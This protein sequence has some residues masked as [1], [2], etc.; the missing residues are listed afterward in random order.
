MKKVIA[1][2]LCGIIMIGVATGCGQ[3]EN[4]SD[5][6]L[7]KIDVDLTI[8]ESVDR[9]ISCN[10][11][12]STSKENPYTYEIVMPNWKRYTFLSEATT[13]KQE[14]KEGKLTKSTY[15]YGDGFKI[16]IGYD[17]DSEAISYFPNF[18][19]SVTSSLLYPR[20]GSPTLYGNENGYWYSYMAKD[21]KIEYKE[22]DENDFYAMISKETDIVEENY[23]KRYVL[24][25]TIQAM[26]ETEEGKARLNYLF[27]ELKDI[28][29]DT[30]NIDLT[31]LSVDMIKK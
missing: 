5:S 14:C 31:E 30:Y 25:I 7:N 13:D 28:Y 1:G 21:N 4:N 12:S 18:K 3:K 8:D 22:N 29:K 2:L 26:Y 11:V 9:T 15:V 23:K 16:Y 20:V 10:L 19:E 24:D 17:L 27:N 6:G